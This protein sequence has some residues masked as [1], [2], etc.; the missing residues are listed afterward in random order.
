MTKPSTCR[1]CGR[2]IYW[3]R[4]ETTGKHAPID[5]ERREGGNIAIDLEHGYYHVMPLVAG[6][7]AYVNHFS[8]CPQQ[9]AWRER[10][11]SGRGVA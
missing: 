11:R 1:S 6:L 10:G 9:A 5:A 3:L 7:P 8:V 2:P 4:H